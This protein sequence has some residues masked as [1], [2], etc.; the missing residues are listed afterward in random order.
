MEETRDRNIF[1]LPSVAN[2]YDNYYQRD[3][4]RIIDRIEK[5][6]FAVHLNHTQKGHLL[7]LG[8]GTG[9]WTKFFSE[10]G[11]HVTAIDNSAA[12]LKIAEKKNIPNTLFRKA[13]ASRLPFPNHSFSTIVSVTMLEFVKD[14]HRVI[15]ETDRVLK[16]GGTLILGCLN[17]LSELGKNKDN[18]PVFR[19]GHFLTPDEIEQLLSR[20]GQPVITAGVYF[21][22]GFEIL[23]GTEKQQTVQP[24]FI[25]A[26]VQKTNKDDGN[27]R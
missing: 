8:C 12:M 10:Q 25:A 14:I 27:N 1:K 22:S 23:D 15:Y 3:G 16:P 19:Y 20:F 26:S 17:A 11:F 18:D 6:I 4:G 5:E 2:E 21:S 13:D 24:A 7:E 9:H